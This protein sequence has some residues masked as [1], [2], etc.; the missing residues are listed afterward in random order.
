MQQA[1]VGGCDEDSGAASPP[2]T[3]SPADFAIKSEPVA[4]KN[5]GGGV[6]VKVEMPEPT[7]AG[8]VEVKGEPREDYQ[9]QLNDGYHYERNDKKPGYVPDAPGQCQQPHQGY[10]PVALPPNSFG[11]PP[12]YGHHHHHPTMMPASFPG[13]RPSPDGPIGKI[14]DGH[15]QQAASHAVER[16][17]AAYGRMPPPI[18]NDGFL[19]EH[20]HR[21]D[22]GDFPNPGVPYPGFRPTISR[23]P[24]GNH[25]NNSVYNRSGHYHPT[26]QRKWSSAAFRGLHPPMPWPTWFFRPD[27]P[28][29]GPLPTSH[30]PN[31]SNVTTSSPLPSRTHLD[32]AK[33]PEPPSNSNKVH[34]QTPTICTSIRCTVNGCACESFTPGKR[35]LRYCENCHHGWVPHGKIYPTALIA[36]T[37]FYSTSMDILLIHNVREDCRG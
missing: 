3:R 23:S 8:S 5:D 29:G 10:R 21:Y 33:G 13:G 26:R 17:V 2:A 19:Q 24:Y 37:L 36:Q 25:Q 4:D 34:G 15:E 20:H 31:S 7:E 35:H 32:V 28:L 11:F 14:G 27:L 18:P 22:A 6:R 30:V 16:H 1:S 9:R 12:F